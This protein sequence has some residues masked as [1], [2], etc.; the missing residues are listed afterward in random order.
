MLPVVSKPA[1]KCPSSKVSIC[2]VLADSCCDIA[3]FKLMVTNGIDWS[4]GWQ[5][6]M[7]GL[8]KE[9]VNTSRIV[10]SWRTHL[11]AGAWRT[12]LGA[13]AGAG[14]SVCVIRLALCI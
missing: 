2:T 9:A 6:D 13:G 10:R 11:G 14:A 12:H 5:L 8:D 1:I 7:V 3:F 4:I